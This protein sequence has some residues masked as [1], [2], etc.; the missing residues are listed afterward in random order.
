MVLIRPPF[1]YR[2]IIGF[3]ALVNAMLLV[4]FMIEI[5]GGESGFFEAFMLFV[6][7]YMF[8]YFGWMSYLAWLRPPIRLDGRRLYW[9][10]GIAWMYRKIKLEDVAS[11]R[12]QDS[13]DLRL[14][15]ST[16]EERSIHLHNTSK[17]ERKELLEHI[18]LNTGDL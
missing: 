6:G 14:K 1:W 9:R 12:M 5:R 18:H 3:G 13:Y 7:A 4:V 8:L 17:Q 16:G 11:F 2:V 10:P 15:M